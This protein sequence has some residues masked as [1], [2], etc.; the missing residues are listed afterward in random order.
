MKK[1][2]LAFLGI[3]LLSIGLS[4]C[5]NKYNSVPLHSVKYYM[6]HTKQRN[7]MLKE[8]NKMTPPELSRH[9]NSN[10]AKDCLNAFNSQQNSQTPYRI[11]PGPPS[12]MNLL[13]GN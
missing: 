1:L 13:G 3:T 5:S 8:C 2:L 4:G 7:L 12:S 11:P 6:K 10:L 9:S